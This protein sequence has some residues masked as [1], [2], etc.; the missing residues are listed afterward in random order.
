MEE[1]GGKQANIWM[2]STSMVPV[3]IW[4]WGRMEWVD[5][6]V[7]GS[8]TMKWKYQDDLCGCGQV[9]TE[10]H[11]L[12]EGNRYG[13]ERERWRGTIEILKDDMCEYEVIQGHHVYS[14]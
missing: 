1:Y 10:E 4:K 3:M 7:Y 14:D 13:E 5:G 8:G 12:F 2:C 9:E 11:A 6:V